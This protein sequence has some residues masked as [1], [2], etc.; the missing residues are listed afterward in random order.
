MRTMVLVYLPT[1]LGD[2]VEVNVG[3]YS[4]TMV[5]IWVLYFL[6]V[7]KPVCH[8]PSTKGLWFRYSFSGWWLLWR[9]VMVKGM[10]T[11]MHWLHYINI[12]SSLILCDSRWW[13]SP[14]KEDYPLLSPFS[15]YPLTVIVHDPLTDY[16]LMIIDPIRKSSLNDGFYL[17]N[18]I[19]IIT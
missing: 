1:E 11:T 6:S 5:R 9:T 16:P 8:K 14:C 17:W 4:S 19:R 2:F 18:W 7:V 12:H 13:I 3:K 10:V 15:D